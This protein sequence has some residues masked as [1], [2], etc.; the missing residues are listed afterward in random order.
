MTI[1]SGHDLA[2]NH[3]LI[4]VYHPPTLWLS[5]CTSAGL[6]EMRVDYACDQTF[7]RD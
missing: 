2:S 1:S 4:C 7:L 6:R 5:R 3:N